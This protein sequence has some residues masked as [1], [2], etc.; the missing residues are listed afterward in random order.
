MVIIAKLMAVRSNF[1]IESMIPPPSV[2]LLFYSK[3]FTFAQNS[4]KMTLSFQQIEVLIAQWT[5]EKKAQL[6]N[7]L[8]KDLNQSYP[9]IEKTPNVCGGSACII[10]TRIPVWTLVSYRNDGLSDATL[11]DAYPTLRPQDL[12][13]AWAYYAGNKKEIDQDIRENEE[14]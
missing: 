8:V 6:L 4:F 9:G 10:R 12:N 5:F 14:D 13:N 2:F 3:K 7:F 11:L 1:L